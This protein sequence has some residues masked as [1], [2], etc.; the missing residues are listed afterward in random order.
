MARSG[1]GRL[2]RKWIMWFFTTV[3]L[4][5]TG[6]LVILLSEKFRWYGLFPILI[7]LVGGGYY[8]QILFWQLITWTPQGLM[9]APLIRQETDRS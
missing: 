1:L 8:T 9:G 2:K 4:V 6:L 7:A 5:V 3:F